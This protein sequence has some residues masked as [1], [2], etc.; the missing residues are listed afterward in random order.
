MAARQ[1]A[2]VGAVGKVLG[3]DGAGRFLLARQP[4]GVR[5]LQARSRSFGDQGLPSLQSDVYASSKVWPRRSLKTVPMTISGAV[6]LV[7]CLQA[8]A[9]FAVVIAAWLVAAPIGARIPNNGNG[10]DGAAVQAAAP[11]ER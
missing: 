7:Y 1:L 11:A 4:L 5:L 10:I 6:V 3:T 8:W 9:A 2:Q